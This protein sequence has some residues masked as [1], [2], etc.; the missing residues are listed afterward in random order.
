[1]VHKVIKDSQDQEANLE[2]KD[3]TVLPD[4][5]ALPEIPDQKDQVVLL[6]RTVDKDH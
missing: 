6:A 5:R 2:I 4:L 1:M 3:L